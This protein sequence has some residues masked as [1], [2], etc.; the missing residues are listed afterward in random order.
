MKDP[1][2]WALRFDDLIQP[3][4]FEYFQ[5]WRG[6]ET[7]PCTMTDGTA[8]TAIAWYILVEADAVNHRGSII[9]S[10]AATDYDELVI[11]IAE[12]E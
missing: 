10:D 4:D 12:T 1:A 5:S 11:T 7:G 9:A 6:I 8:G 2:E 3:V